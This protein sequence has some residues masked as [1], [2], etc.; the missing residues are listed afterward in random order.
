MSNT[1]LLRNGRHGFRTVEEA[2]GQFQSAATAREPLEVEGRA[3]RRRTS[4]LIERLRSSPVVSLGSWPTPIQRVTRRGQCD[5]LIKRD[6]LSGFGR[7]GA[8]ARK[9]SHL[10]GHLRSRGHGEL[11]AMAGNVTNLAFDL[12][13]ASEL[14]GI[15]TRL[16]IV[17]DPFATER[18]RTKIFSGVANR[19]E[20]LQ[21][22]HTEAAA[23]VLRAYAAAWR[24]G[25]RPFLALPGASH[26]ACVIGNA[27][28]FL[29]MVEQLDSQGAPLPRAV[30]VTAATGT[31]VAGF[32]LG[33][34][35]LLAAGGPYIQVIGV[36]VF[37]G[38]IALRTRALARWT[39]RFLRSKRRTPICQANFVSSRL[40]FA[41]FGTATPR[42]CSRVEEELGIQVDPIF[43]G[44][45]WEAMEADVSANVP[46][47][48]PL[49]YW[50]CGYTPEWQTLR[51]SVA[52]V[53]EVTT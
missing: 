36:Q 5:L 52:G 23:V 48:R 29:E 42:L 13:L 44:K 20:L 16:F 27:C 24:A 28:G 14:V 8:K 37:P 21:G 12:S 51:A 30:F 38:R 49:L 39:E 10:L 9:V 26:P 11:L 7:G 43:G 6:D 32:L 17:N 4:L 19:V 45:T 2:T 34:D 31:T 15:R 33:A 1:I 40:G 18:E 3:R 25:R 41:Q 22:G 50:H 47:E 53:R 46:N 35:A